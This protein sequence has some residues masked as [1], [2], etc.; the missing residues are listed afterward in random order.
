[1][2]Q[3]DQIRPV[4]LDRMPAAESRSATESGNFKHNLSCANV[5]LSSNTSRCANS[6]AITKCGRFG[7]FFPL[8]LH[9][10]I[11]IDQVGLWDTTETRSPPKVEATNDILEMFAPVKCT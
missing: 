3:W 4:V 1:M 10:F 11:E 8:V 7:K 5:F 6:Y 2:F 9:V